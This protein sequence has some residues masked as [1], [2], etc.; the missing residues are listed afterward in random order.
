MREVK[1]NIKL[2]FVTS[3]G[4][5]FIGL[6]AAYT[7]TQVNYSGSEEGN[8]FSAGAASDTSP[9]A[10]ADVGMSYEL[11]E[12]VASAIYTEGEIDVD[13][14]TKILSGKFSKQGSENSNL[15]L[16]NEQDVTNDIYI[17]GNQVDELSN[18]SVLEVRGVTFSGSGSGSLVIEP[19][20]EGDIDHLPENTISVRFVNKS[21]VGSF[22]AAF[23]G[24]F[25]GLT[26]DDMSGDHTNISNIGNTIMDVNNQGTF[27]LIGDVIEDSITKND[28]IGIYEGGIK[29]TNQSL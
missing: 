19:I 13:Y 29:I 4:L 15:A 8:D 22:D 23:K 16:V 25:T 7:D 1:D 12:I 14:G 21:N 28:Q 5:G 27:V 20:N 3:L 24:V 17:T 26:P 2:L 9:G 10:Y 18:L 11:S 6:Q